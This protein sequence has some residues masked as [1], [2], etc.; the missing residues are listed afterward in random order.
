[1]SHILGVYT[2]HTWISTIFR[3]CFIYWY[4]EFR[5]NSNAEIHNS[6]SVCYN[7]TYSEK[8]T[9]AELLSPWCVEYTFIARNKMIRV[10]SL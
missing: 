8:D 4:K 1:M 5:I 3:N 6:P 9:S 2:V 10:I 7:N